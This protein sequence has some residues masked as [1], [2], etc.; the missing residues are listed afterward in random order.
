MELK[1]KDT[2]MI[3]G[4][5]VL[6]MLCLHLF[7]KDYH[8]IFKPLI[9]IEGI[10]LSFYLG[11]LS[12][13]CVFGFAFCSG[14]GHLAQSKKDDYYKTR[15]KSLLVLLVNYWVV[16]I[17]FSLISIVAGECSNMPGTIIEFVLNFLTLSNS[18]NGAWWYLSTYILLVLLSPII[19]KIVE[20]NNVFV[21]LLLSFS[22]YCIAFYYRFYGDAST[23]L[24]G[25]CCLFGMTLFEY[26]LG[27]ISLKYKI[28]SKMYNFY[29]QIDKKYRNFLSIMLFI[30]ML[31]G[32]TKVVPNVFVAP[33]TGFILIMLF[34]FYSKSNWVEKSLLFIGKHSTNI[35]LTHMFFYM[36]IFDNFVYLV[37]YPFLIYAFMLMLT[38]IISSLLQL[39]QKPSGNKIIEIYNKFMKNIHVI[40]RK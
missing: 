40:N 14:Y 24:I 22:I 37:K 33:I 23:W 18:F 25:K 2:K 28:F 11:Q 39:V 7:C 1:Q 9:F 6:A 27:A 17:M 15:I 34:H 32:R 13:F 20:K 5:S 38:I 31:Y 16:L 36:Y 12:D 4:L 35:W 19:L 26:I 21:V 3:Q 10:P 29:I 30:V 8:G